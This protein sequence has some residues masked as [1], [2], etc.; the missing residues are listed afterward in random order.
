MTILHPEE[1]QA[2]LHPHSHKYDLISMAHEVNRRLDAGVHVAMLDLDN[3]AKDYLLPEDKWGPAI[4]PNRFKQPG[5]VD[6]GDQHF[7]EATRRYANWGRAAR[8]FIPLDDEGLPV[9]I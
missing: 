4:G 1:M 7:L 8:G 3:L 2:W 9:T 5:N 6:Y